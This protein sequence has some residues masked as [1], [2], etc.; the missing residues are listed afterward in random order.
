MRFVN[1]LLFIL[2]TILFAP[3]LAAQSDVPQARTKVEPV[4]PYGGIYAI[5]EATVLPD[6]TLDY[7]LVIDVYSGHEDPDSVVQGLHNVA[8]MLNLFSVGGV[9]EEQVDVVLAVHGG[10]TF[11]IIDN[12]QYRERF[13]TDNPNAGLVTALKRAGVKITVCG[14][15]LIGRDIPTDAI[16]PEVELATSMLTTVAMYQMRGYGVMRF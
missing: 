5:P 16:L 9:P 3:A 8:R 11:G 13:G 1:Y 14:Q 10:A 4:V 15:S 12:E 2:F 7:R 6:P